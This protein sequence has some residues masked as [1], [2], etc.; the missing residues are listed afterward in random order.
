MVQLGDFSIQL[1]EPHSKKPYREHYHGGK[2]Y[3]EINHGAE[4]FIAC[5]KPCAKLFSGT[6]VLRFYVDGNYLGFNLSYT[7]AS[8]SINPKYKGNWKREDGIS[9]DTAIPFLP[10]STTA[11]CCSGSKSK[12]PSVFGKVKVKVFPTL[13]QT[14]DGTKQNGKL[15][16]DKDCLL[17]TITLYCG[18]RQDLVQAGV[19]TEELSSPPSVQLIDSKNDIDNNRQND[20]PPRKPTRQSA[21]TNA[22]ECNADFTEEDDSDS[23]SAIH[24]F[25][26]ARSNA[27]E[28]FE[29][30]SVVFVDPDMDVI[31]IDDLSSGDEDF[32]DAIR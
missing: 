1:V 15:G 27:E 3:V 17:S 22:K 23:E 5:S 19:I 6:V 30:D 11:S 16:Y 12:K 9:T 26:N 10:P 32:H 20:A 13:V 21:R 14:A 25:R 4:Y 29:T 24:M 31:A 18:T 7:A 28:E 2:T 8:K